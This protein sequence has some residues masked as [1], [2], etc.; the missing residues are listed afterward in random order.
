[1]T[2][3]ESFPDTTLSL[4]IPCYNEEGNI[5]ALYARV[6]SLLLNAPNSEA[7]FV[8]N[9]STDSTGALLLSLIGGNSRIKI[10]HVEHNRGYGYG[11][12]KGLEVT[13]GSI[14]GWTHADLQSDPLDALRGLQIAGKLSENLFIKGLRKRRPLFDKL[15]SLGMSVFESMLFK[16]PL[17]D[18]NAQPTLFS[19]SLI[20]EVLKGPDDFS[21]DLYA[22]VSAVRSGF[23]EVRF[24][25]NYEARLKGSSTWNT[26]WKARFR[27]ISRI[28][29][30]SLA[31][32]NGSPK[33]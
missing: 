25:V 13:T 15:F 29:K 3:T 5:P 17:R 14:V 16:T 31:L 21:L 33:R 28:C 32:A 12:K 18:I 30:S 6:S 22:L 9:G 8:D 23:R 2:K 26:S 20:G 7:V 27:L 4:V 11:I 1:M 24:P 10:V 19:R